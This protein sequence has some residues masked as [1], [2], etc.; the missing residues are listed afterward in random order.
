[1]SFDNLGLS[2]VLTATVA[3]LG[4]T[5]PTPIQSQ[6]IP[7]VLQ[8]RDLMAGAQ[9]GTGK[10]AAFALPM[11]ERLLL[12]GNAAG[13]RRG[14]AGRPRALILVPTREL[15]AQVHESFRDYGARL[16]LLS[17]TIFGGVGIQPQIQALRRQLDVVVATPGRL[18]DH[19]Q[20]RTVDLSGIEIL[21]LDEADRMLDMGFMPSIR[22]ILQ[23]LPKNRHT[24][25]F[26]A[27]FMPEIKTLA[28][29][30]MKNPAEVQVATMNS[31]ASTIAHQVHPV[32]AE[33][34]RDLIVHLLRR[35]RG[36]TLI[37]RISR[38]AARG[39]SSLQTLRHGGWISSNSPW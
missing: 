22:R 38:P 2:P 12:T 20:Q 8:G 6:A 4:Y 3:Q 32:S 13:P 1:V 24:L 5:T 19:M 11:I 35:D 7:V 23:A 34:K 9:T 30:F 27:T 14:A 36:Q 39:Y 15:A 10:T 21:T 26:S 31:I 37:F 25:L 16:G 18:L 28:A 29:Q 17:T 33:R